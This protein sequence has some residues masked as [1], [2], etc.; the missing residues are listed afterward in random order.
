[1]DDELKK[2]GLV[3]SKYSEALNEYSDIIK[4]HLTKNKLPYKK[5]GFWLSSAAFKHGFFIY[6]PKNMV[7]DE[8]IRIINYLSENGFFYFQKY[9]H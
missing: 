4:K 8:P 5:T 3:I 2:G 7:I 6:V 9:Y 1:M